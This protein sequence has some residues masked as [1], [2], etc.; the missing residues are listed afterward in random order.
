MNRYFTAI[1]ATV[2]ATLTA[3]RA[4]AA[5]FVKS[6]TSTCPRDAVLAGRTCIDKFESSLWQIPPTNL[7]GESN[8]KVITKIRSG[9]VTLA[10]LTAAN[11]VQVG[12]FGEGAPTSSVCNANGQDCRDKL[13]AVSLP[14]VFPSNASYFQALMACANSLKRLPTTQEWMVAVAGSPDVG[15]AGPCNVGDPDHFF[16]ATGSQP[17]CK[18]VWGAFDMVGNM[19]EYTAELVEDINFPPWTDSFSNNDGVAELAV[20]RGGGFSVGANSLGPNPGPFSN[21]YEY[22]YFD[23]Q[24]NPFGVRCTR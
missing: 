24:P 3:G 12:R 19:G 11:A 9:T 22:P 6:T 4:S 18:S 7:A 20:I 21:R 13:Y 14:G 10:D 2:L 16:R 5:G 23:A 1:A 15:Q 8:A 17:L